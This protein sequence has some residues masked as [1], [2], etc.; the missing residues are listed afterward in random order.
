MR[1]SHNRLSTGAD[2]G[3]K[4]SGRTGK[5]IIIVR[6]FSKPVSVLRADQFSKRWSLISGGG[7]EDGSPSEAYATSS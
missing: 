4:L 3:L 5:D 2:L 7:D 1:G 6:T